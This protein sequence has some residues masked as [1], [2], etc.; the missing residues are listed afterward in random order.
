MHHIT[1][2]MVS[3]SG[4]QAFLLDGKAEGG[5][6]CVCLVPPVIPR[7]FHRPGP[8]QVHSDYSAARIKSLWE[9]HL[10]V[11]CLFLEAPGTPRGVGVESRVV[12]MFGGRGQES[13]K[14]RA[15]SAS[16]RPGSPPS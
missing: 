11:V 1:D 9:L 3:L 12:R 13:C 8:L 6:D 10:L 16:H 2:L 14:H 7:A 5:R 4:N 15:C